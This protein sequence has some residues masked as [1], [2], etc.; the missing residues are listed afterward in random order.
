MS[1]IEYCSLWGAVAF[2]VGYLIGAILVYHII[3]K[4]AIELGIWEQLNKK[5]KGDGV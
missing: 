1:I 2:M 3:K 5:L 4:R